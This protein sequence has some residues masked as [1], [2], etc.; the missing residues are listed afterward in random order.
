MLRYILAFAAA[1]SL[2]VLLALAETIRRPLA[3]LLRAVLVGVVAVLAT[4]GLAIGA[5]GL[6]NEAWWAAIIG[7]AILLGA[8]RLGWALR[9]PG[10]RARAASLE[11][12]HVPL[13]AAL[14]DSHW[15]RFEAQLDW[16][17]RKEVGRSRAA[18]DG[19]LAERQSPSLTNDHRSLM[20]SCEKRIPELIDTCIDRC[21]NATGRERD[22]YID[23]TLARI[24]QIG[25]EAERARVEVRAADDQRLH[26]LHRYFDGVTGEPDQRSTLP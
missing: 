23:E 16:V 8:G 4:L 3:R 15:R 10:G 21:R 1:L 12:P 13:T 9:R 14:P 17:S 24:R 2:G 7:A 20:V 22:H 19:F 11:P 18:I 26:V 25:I 5:A 6:A